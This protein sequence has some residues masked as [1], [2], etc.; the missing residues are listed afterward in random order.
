MSPKRTAEV[1]VRRR[2]DAPECEVIV[3]VGGQEMT[4]KCR[5]YNEAVKW[6]RALIS[7]RRVRTG[8]EIGRGSRRPGLSTPAHRSQPGPSSHRASSDGF[9][10]MIDAGR[11]GRADRAQLRRRRHG[12]NVSTRH[13]PASERQ[14]RSWSGLRDLNPKPPSRVGTALC[15]K[16]SPRFLIEAPEC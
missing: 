7:R 2:S 3:K 11:P 8:A 9:G 1:K 12:G 16:L 13:A 4:L 5:D 6:G 15:H 14:K 10:G